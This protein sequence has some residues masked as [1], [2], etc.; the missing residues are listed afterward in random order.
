MAT[1]IKSSSA[2]YRPQYEV[3]AERIAQIIVAEELQAGDRLATESE[4]TE[5][6]GLSRSVIHEAVKVLAATGRVRTRKGG[7]IFVGT[8]EAPHRSAFIDVS[9]SVDPKDVAGLFIFR[10][11]L[12]TQAARLAASGISLRE[13]RE[14]QE[15][16]NRNRAAALAENLEHFHESDIAFHQGIADATHNPFFASAIMAVLRLMSWAV[17]L[18]VGGTPG[19]LLVAAEQHQAILNAL[20]G[21]QGEAAAE[22]MQAHLQTVM[23]SYQRELRRRLVGETTETLP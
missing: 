14:L 13:V 16:V 7:G 5:R 19:S 1:G 6:L 15:A 23:T 8:P 2:P 20:Q 22:A 9:M 12:E 21:E 11:T 3:A 18:A 10:S 4:L 17:E